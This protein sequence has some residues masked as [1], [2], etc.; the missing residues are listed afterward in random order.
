[1]SDLAPF[2]NY[3]CPNGRGVAHLT[4]WTGAYL[5]PKPGDGICICGE[6]MVDEAS[7]ADGWRYRLEWESV[8]PHEAAALEKEYGSGIWQ[9]LAAGQWDALSWHPVSREHG[10]PGSIHQQFLNLKAW[11][12]SHEQPVRNVRLLRSAA[13]SWA[14]VDTSMEEQR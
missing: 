14:V 10:V 7:T 8:D 5:V 6:V 9:R 2:T 11:A 12:E 4:L 13:Q 3:I 1:M